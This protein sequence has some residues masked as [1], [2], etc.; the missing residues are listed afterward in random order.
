MQ[1]TRVHL[2]PNMRPHA[3][4]CACT[5]TC[6]PTHTRSCGAGASQA[7]RRLSTRR[8]SQQAPSSQAGS[9]STHGEMNTLPEVLAASGA[10][11]LGG[12]QLCVERF[13][14]VVLDA[15]K[16]GEH[17]DS[18]LNSIVLFHRLKPFP[19]ECRAVRQ[20]LSA[21]HADQRPLPRS[22]PAVPAVCCCIRRP[23]RC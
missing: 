11:R 12:Y 20:H 6:T 21:R 19:T 2:R 18:V 8:A 3:G 16:H 4:A 13:Q 23:C 17:T 5:R 10:F 7:P 14:V 9:E 1:C 15:R 22:H